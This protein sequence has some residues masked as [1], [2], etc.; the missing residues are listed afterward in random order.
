M[1]RTIF[2]LLIIHFTFLTACKKTFLDVEDNN[3]V[4]AEQYV[5]DVTS[6]QQYLNGIYV[7]LARDFYGS[8]LSQ[9]IIPEIMA[10]NVKP[11][12]SS[13]LPEY[14]WEVTTTSSSSRTDYLWRY[15]YQ[16]ARNCS[17]L[18]EKAAS[19]ESEDASKA[20][21][22]QAEAYALRAYVHFIMV[23]EY[24]QSYNYTADASHPGIPYI[25]S[26]DWTKFVGRG[27]AAKDYEAMINDL[28]IAI[29][30]YSSSTVNPLV[31]NK[32]ASK[33]LLARIY[34]FKEDWQKARE[35]A[36]EVS[37]AVP[38]MINTPTRNMYPDSL[39]RKGES[40]ALFQMA[41]ASKSA[42]AG[43][44]D[45]YFIGVRFRKDGFQSMATKDIADILLQNPN[46]RRKAWINRGTTGL[47]TIYKYPISVVPGFGTGYDAGRSYYQTLLR[48]SEMYLTIAEASAKLGDDNAARTY[49]D[50]I[51]K[52]ADVTA[53][54]STASG[55]TLLDSIYLERRKEMAFEGLRMFD[56]LRWKK[57]V[58]RTDAVLGSPTMLPYPSDKAIAPIPAID[59]ASGI[60]QNTGY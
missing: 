52:R 25:T 18:I 60:S 32:M 12:G 24:A 23:N 34:L 58:N 22:M 35:Q 6:G 44:Y 41:P 46:D 51:R 57:G 15:G 26:F 49:L 42:I 14:N 47:D 39:F 55:A 33:A 54:S 43:S 50:A 19:F 31:M 1:K 7:V 21:Q 45:T 11:A 13:L 5:K 17:F 48:S 37:N 3:E 2:I 28:N 16:I 4:L 53:A 10:D 9:Q 30:L 20:H 59:A 56:L 38:L 8:S 36:T 29:G 27:T 40:E